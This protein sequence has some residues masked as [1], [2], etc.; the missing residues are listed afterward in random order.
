MDIS[1]RKRSNTLRS[2][3][4][5]RWHKA[6]MQTIIVRIFPGSP[7]KQQTVAIIR[8]KRMKY[9]IDMMTIE[10]TGF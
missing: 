5:V 9:P 6:F 3:F 2:K 7:N 8:R 1:A 4:I 10:P